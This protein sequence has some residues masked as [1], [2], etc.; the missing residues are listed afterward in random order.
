MSPEW[1]RHL[2]CLRLRGL[3]DSL[4]NEESSLI[5]NLK[6]FYLDAPFLTSRPLLTPANTR[7]PIS[8]ISI[9][10]ALQTPL[11][12]ILL[13]LAKEITILS[14]PHLKTRYTRSWIICRRN[15][16]HITRSTQSQNNYFF[17][18]YVFHVTCFMIMFDLSLKICYTV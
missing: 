18:C 15:N 5:T 6:S 11:L 1:V 12:T 7:V 16:Y 13:F 2:S 10:R 9:F 4:K 3:A 14:S 8:D 17:F